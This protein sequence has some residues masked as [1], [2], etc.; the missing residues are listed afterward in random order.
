[1][2]DQFE[3]DSVSLYT[4]GFV[5]YDSDSQRYVVEP[6]KGKGFTPVEVNKDDPFGNQSDLVETLDWMAEEWFDEPVRWFVVHCAGCKFHKNFRDVAKRQGL[7]EGSTNSGRRVKF[8][9]ED[10]RKQI[11]L[12]SHVNPKDAIYLIFTNGDDEDAILEWCVFY[13]AG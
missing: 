11:V 12:P 9:S 8:E 1:M 5:E 7:L 10:L 13:P 4:A 3:T 2:N 6:C